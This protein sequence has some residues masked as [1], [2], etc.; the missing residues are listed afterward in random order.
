[1]EGH[2]VLHRPYGFGVRAGE[3]EGWWGD[4]CRGVDRVMEGV[5]VDITKKDFTD[6]VFLPAFLD[7]ELATFMWI[8]IPR[9]AEWEVSKPYRACGGSIE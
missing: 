5:V 6:E 1:M 2:D 8:C 3:E 9:G 4:G 7:R